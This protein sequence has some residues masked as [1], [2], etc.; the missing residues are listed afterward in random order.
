LLITD[1]QVVT[2]NC[3]KVAPL[4]H[5]VRRSLAAQALK[6]IAQAHETAWQKDS[7]A[8]CGNRLIINA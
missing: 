3:N 2:S 1:L 4:S 8:V 7:A 6:R 5:K